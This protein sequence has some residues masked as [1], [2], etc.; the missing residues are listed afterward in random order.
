MSP[1]RILGPALTAPLALLGCAPSGVDVLLEESLRDAKAAVMAANYGDRG[2]AVA[3]D[4][5]TSPVPF[6]GELAMG[7]GEVVLWTYDLPLSFLGLEAGELSV[8]GHCP[9]PRATREFRLEG[10]GLVEVPHATSM[11]LDHARAGYVLGECCA[12][13]TECAGC[14]LF[15]VEPIDIPTT[16]PYG[17]GASLDSRRAWVRYLGLDL[18]LEGSE[19]VATSVPQVSPWGPFIRGREVFG[20]VDHTLVKLDLDRALEVLDGGGGLS[21]AWE[22]VATTTIATLGILSGSPTTEPLELFSHYYD[23]TDEASPSE[24]SRWSPSGGFELLASGILDY[25]RIVRAGPRKVL[26]LPPSGVTSRLGELGPGG[27]SEVELL[28]PNG[29]N[30]TYFVDVRRIPGVGLVAMGASADEAHVL[31]RGDDG[32]FRPYFST[33]NPRTTTRVSLA[34]VGPRVFVVGAGGFLEV[35]MDE[36]R[37]CPPTLTPEEL[38]IRDGVP[39]E[40]GIYWMTEGR[41]PKVLFARPRATDEL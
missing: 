34:L 4:P 25:R 40:G 37:A 5:R 3:F 23:F 12:F 1:V 30:S 16:A 33:K 27:L 38:I 39:V 21:A 28:W 31:R 9:V 8:T 36:R 19:V 41:T 11:T 29:S 32:P 22:T 26:L 13:A 10:G 14:T 24:I 17:F 35:F 15:D 20:G 2:L 6:Q 7:E 18:V